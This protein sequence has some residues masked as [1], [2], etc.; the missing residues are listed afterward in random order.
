MAVAKKTVA[1]AT[2]KKKTDAK[3][4]AAKQVAAKPAAKGKPAAAKPVKPAA[5]PAN[6]K[7]ASSAKNAT[8]SKAAAPARPV[9]AKKPAKAVATK[10]GNAS[11]ATAKPA[12]AAAKGAAKPAAKQTKAEPKKEAAAK[13]SKQALVKQSKA[14]PARKAVAP[15]KPTS[16]KEMKN[17]TGLPSRSLTTSARPAPK[18]AAVKGKA[19]PKVPAKAVPS[20]QAKGKGAGASI[21]SPAKLTKS[22]NRTVVRATD[23]GT[24]KFAAPAIVLSGP[25]PVKETSKPITKGKDDKKMITNDGKPGID[26]NKISIKSAT[27]QAPSK[28]GRKLKPDELKKLQ[29]MLLHERERIVDEMRILDERSL[30]AN[31]DNEDSHQ[32][33]FS[34]QLADSATDNIQI[35]TD[36]AIRNIE[37]E[38][39]AQ[40][41]DALRAIET[42]DYGICNRCQEAIDF[43]RLKAKPNARFCVSC[44]RLLE[45]G[46]A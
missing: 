14:A 1:K 21:P 32:P 5:K 34:L 35:E 29:K 41:D 6:A 8:A 37:A 13:V 33:G 42:G 11:T 36:L 43:E 46:K 38:Q 24:Q 25:I 26:V 10:S 39:L 19:A 18:K 27:P 7:T 23:K 45:A 44:L 31:P 9:A 40:I 4:A 16:K 2:A 15:G 3:P 20:I 22:K 17:K 30:T 12:K 28:R